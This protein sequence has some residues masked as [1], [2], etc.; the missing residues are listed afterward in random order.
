[1][2]Q[3]NGMI[4]A[5]SVENPLGVGFKLQLDEGES[6]KNVRQKTSRKANLLDCNLT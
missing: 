1:M 5:K 4:H 2:L 3:E 6:L